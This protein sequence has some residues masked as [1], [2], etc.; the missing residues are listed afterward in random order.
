MER[1]PEEPPGHL[2]LPGEFHHVHLGS[3]EAGHLGKAGSEEPPGEDEGLL[4]GV[5][6]VHAGHFPAPGA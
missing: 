2:A 5:Q 6:E 4:R 1:V 3:P